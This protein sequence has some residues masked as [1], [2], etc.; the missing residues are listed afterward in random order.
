MNLESLLSTYPKLLRYMED[1]DYSTGYIKS[2][3]WEI[4][5]LRRTKGKYNFASYEEMLRIRIETGRRGKCSSGREHHLRSIYA[6]L[7]RFE[8][9]GIFPDR[10]KGR[11]LRSRSSYFKLLPEFQEVMNLYKDYAEK[12]GLKESTIKKRMYKGSSFLLYMQTNGCNSLSS[13]S[14]SD[15]LSFFTDC[16]GL[17]VLSS[18]HKREIAAIFGARLGIYSE[19]AH[20]IVDYLPDIRKRR[21]NIRYLTAEESEAIRNCL[22]DSGNNLTARNR[23]LGMLL[24]FTGLRA[25]DAAN[26]CFE[27]IDWEKDEIHIL[28][29]KSGVP[30][31]IP[32]SAVVGNAILDYVQ[33]ERPASDNSQ[34]FLC[35]YPPYDP[36]SGDTMWMITS[37]IY[38]A[39]GIRTSKGD[40]RGAHLFRYHLATHLAEQGVS[41]PIISEVLGHEAP[42]S[43]DYYLSADIAHLRECALS[44]EEFPVCE[45]VFCV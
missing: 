16:D 38:K 40:R 30:V 3:E 19:N 10:R 33:N 11:P 36:I 4:K 27:D 14:E 13:I 1:N 21:A 28:Q 39:A 29:H 31:N 32:L 42:E 37:T 22:N 44:I 5:W 17:A 24:Y 20:R 12:E 23:A 9:D 41:K 34:I 6:T 18:T 8:E 35:G 45:E 2:F 26:M 43:L 25:S 7:Q 15:V